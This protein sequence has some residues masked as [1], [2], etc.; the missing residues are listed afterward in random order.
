MAQFLVSTDFHSHPA[1][2]RASSSA[3]GLWVRAGAWSARHN[4][5]G[6]ITGKAA[7]TLGTTIA[8]D[9]LLRSGLWERAKGGYRM[10]K[11]VPAGRGVELWR[12][13]RSDQRD[14]IPAHVRRTV[15]ARDGHACLWCGA[16][17]D[18]TLDHIKPWS[19]G[20]PDTVENL[21]VLCRSC[22]SSRGAR[23]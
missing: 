20:G 23:V 1:T 9:H 5:N 19:L 10:A 15:F 21:R 16:A 22:N 2:M 8:A 17:A 4:T 18:L 6:H 3:I 12:I 11:R 7:A 13:R 14:H